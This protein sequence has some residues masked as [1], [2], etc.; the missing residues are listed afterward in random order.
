[1]RP[2]SVAQP[3]FTKRL[4]L[5]RVH[6]PSSSH[7]PGGVVVVNH[8]FSPNKRPDPPCFPVMSTQCPSFLLSPELSPRVV[9]WRQDAFFSPRVRLV[10]H[11]PRVPGSIFRDVHTALIFFREEPPP[12]SV[13]CV[14][15]S[16]RFAIPRLQ[17]GSPF[18]VL[19]WGRRGP[20]VAPSPDSSRE[21]GRQRAFEARSK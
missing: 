15:C 21:V 19:F 18:W 1:M 13:S 14:P 17:R 7:A 4:S 10:S 12:L 20:R 2:P 5:S 9:S 16:R 6:P 8:W 11:F 3:S